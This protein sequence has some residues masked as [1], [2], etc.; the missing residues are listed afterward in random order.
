[1]VKVRVKVRF[2]YKK[3][4]VLSRLYGRHISK[5]VKLQISMG[6]VVPNGIIFG[7]DHLVVIVLVMVVKMCFLS[8]I[9]WW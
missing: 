9:I 7:A 4:Y 1:M 6:E 5:S 2:G 3:I 8:P